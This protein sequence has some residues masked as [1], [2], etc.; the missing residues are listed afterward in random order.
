MVA[1]SKPEHEQPYEG[2]SPLRGTASPKRD[3]SIKKSQS[4]K[5][6]KDASP[7]RQSKTDLRESNSSV[8]FAPMPG[9]NDSTYSPNR[10][11]GGVGGPDAESPERYRRG[12]TKSPSGGAPRP[13]LYKDNQG[14]G[15]GSA[16]KG[17]QR[18]R[19]KTKKLNES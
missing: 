6:I 4:S 1:L 13:I 16:K 19:S 12:A 18:G 14:P 15:Y 11:R 2:G 8:R 10:G 5:I 9:A 7:L 3:T 17:S